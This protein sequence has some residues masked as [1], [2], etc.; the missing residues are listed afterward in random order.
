M[1]IHPYCGLHVY[2][3]LLDGYQSLAFPPHYTHVS[4]P[5]LSEYLIFVCLVSLYASLFLFF[6]CGYKQFLEELLDA[7]IHCADQPSYLRIYGVYRDYLHATVPSGLSSLSVST[8][9]DSVVAA[10]PGQWKL[11][12]TFVYVD[13]ARQ[14]W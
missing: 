7:L 12:G 3:S 4:T 8:S 6:V 13:L 14:L 9:P 2:F 11:L 5:R 10:G 1:S